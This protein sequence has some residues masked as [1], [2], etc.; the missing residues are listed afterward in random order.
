M[1]VIYYKKERDDLITPTFGYTDYCFYIPDKSIVLL[2]HT[3]IMW[4]QPDY[5]ADN[6]PKLLEEANHVAQRDVQRKLFTSFSP[7]KIFD[8]D[9]SRLNTILKGPEDVLSKG[10]EELLRQINKK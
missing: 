8:Y 7:P 6:N 3:P 1:K 10:I 2:K 4:Y 9:D 5:K